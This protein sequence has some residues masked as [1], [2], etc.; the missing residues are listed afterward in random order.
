MML[1]K[2]RL[3]MPITMYQTNEFGDESAAYLLVNTVAQ[4]GRLR[5]ELSSV[6][7]S[8][9]MAIRPILVN[10]GTEIDDAVPHVTP[11]SIKATLIGHYEYLQ[12][13]GLVESLEEFERRLQVSKSPNDAF[14]A[15]VV[16]QPDLSNPLYV[17]ATK[18]EFE[19]DFRTY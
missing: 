14:R 15:N 10:D 11:R 9:I 19:L 6:I 3:N 1:G 13:F 5:D 4:L 8:R 7:N 16:Y 2:V 18:I 12:S 17:L